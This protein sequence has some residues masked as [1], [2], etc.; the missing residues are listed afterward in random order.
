MPYACY[1]LCV[2]VSCFVVMSEMQ[3]VLATATYEYAIG[4]E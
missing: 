2:H 1:D 4:F 3:N